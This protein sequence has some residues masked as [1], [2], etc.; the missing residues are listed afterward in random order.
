MK[1]ATIPVLIIFGLWNLTVCQG[2]T[3]PV[4]PQAPSTTQPIP[5][6][7]QQQPIEPA[8]TTPAQ[9]EATVPQ[10]V[11]PATA[12]PE[13]STEPA[14]PA[15]DQLD[16]KSV[17]FYDLPQ[18]VQQRLQTQP[19]FAQI[20]EIQEVTVPIYEVEY[21]RNGRRAQIQL[22]EDGTLLPQESASLQNTEFRL[23]LRNP[24]T[25]GFDQLPPA[26]QGTLRGQ[27]GEASS[28]ETIQRGDLYGMTIYQT[29]FTKNGQFIQ[30][31][32]SGDGSLVGI[33]DGPIRS[34]GAGQEAQPVSPEDIPDPVRRT[35][36]SQTGEEPIESLW[37]RSVPI[38]QVTLRAT[39][40][41]SRY[42]YL[43]RAGQPVEINPAALGSAQQ[44]ETGE[45]TGD[46]NAQRFIPETG[47]S[48]NEIRT[49]QD[50]PLAVRQNLLL[51]TGPIEVQQV[52]KGSIED[53]PAY[54][55]V[56]RRN[57]TSLEVFIS[58]DGK[59]LPGAGAA[60]AGALPAEAGGEIEAPQPTQPLAPTPPQGEQP[61]TLDP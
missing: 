11:P 1:A 18:P 49:M 27:A 44:I 58:E 46:N 3:A 60:P 12:E 14:T 59:V 30:I 36:E 54:R 8:S 7:Q 21:R 42:L 24:Q 9:P 29:G 26:V 13:P 43:T 48:P 4:Q 56:G 33:R 61:Q 28:V 40:D 47:G 20:T 50:L 45:E 22:L 35:I 51:H 15:D 19:I 57:G 23:P 41:Q 32:V 25:I 38:Y 6:P 16:S 31:R 17:S 37:K 10:S 39:A 34:A 52:Q 53:Q 2:Q 55:I 5:T